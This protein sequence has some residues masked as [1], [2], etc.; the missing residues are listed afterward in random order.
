M[1]INVTWFPMTLWFY[2]SWIETMPDHVKC[3]RCFVIYIMWSFSTGN[4]VWLSFTLLQSYKLCNWYCL[5]CG[6][7]VVIYVLYRITNVLFVV[8]F[9]RNSRD[10]KRWGQSFWGNHSSQKS[11]IH[12][13][14]IHVCRVSHCFTT[15][16]PHSMLVSYILVT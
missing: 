14:S 5:P 1:P 4:F 9:S 2:Y 12:I 16:T 6:H 7:L 11:Y 13:V 8:Q 10:W 15:I 3:V